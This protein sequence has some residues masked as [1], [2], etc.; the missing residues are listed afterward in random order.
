MG[1]VCLAD[2]FLPDL[3]DKDARLLAATG[4]LIGI[5]LVGAAALYYADRWRRRQMADHRSTSD[6]L[7]SFRI[8]YERGELSQTEYD[9]IR[10][11]LADKI[12]REAALPPKPA[13]GP[14]PTG[15][16]SPPPA[17]GDPTVQGD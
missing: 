13:E 1:I 3:P 12:K 5:L 16:E 7:T 2:G 14:K 8:L 4:L 10:N 6:D 9:R 11:R 15:G 17:G